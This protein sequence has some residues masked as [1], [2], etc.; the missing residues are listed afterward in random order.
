MYNYSID[1]W[2]LSPNESPI[3]SIGFCVAESSTNSCRIISGSTSILLDSGPAEAK[4][5]A[6]KAIEN[7]LL[8]TSNVQSY[9]PNVVSAQFLR[10]R[11]DSLVIL[12]ADIGDGDNGTTSSAAIVAIGT[13][14]VALLLV[15]TFVYG[16]FRRQ[17]SAKKQQRTLGICT[18]KSPPSSFPVGMNGR[19]Y[20]TRLDDESGIDS[21][22]VSNIYEIKDEPSITWSMSDITSESGSG[23]SMSSR[24]TTR[25]ESIKEEPN[26]GCDTMERPD[27]D[28]TKAYAAHRARLAELIKATHFESTFGA[29]AY[30]VDDAD[31]ISNLKRAKHSKERN[32]LVVVPLEILQSPSLV[33]DESEPEMSSNEFK[34]KPLS[35]NAGDDSNASASE[36]SDEDSNVKT[37]E[38]SKV[39]INANTSG[40]ADNDSKIKTAEDSDEDSNINKSDASGVDSN[41]KASEGSTG[42]KELSLNEPVPKPFCE[43]ASDFNR[44]PNVSQCYFPPSHSTNEQSR[45]DAFGSSNNP[46]QH[47]TNE[48][49]ETIDTNESD[50]SLQR[51]L[52]ILLLEL[53]KCRISNQNESMS[54]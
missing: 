43:A 32:L 2:R 51:W 41:D 42:G 46:D 15:A 17:A 4:T 33:T 38:P 3:C 26:P 19:R 44:S 9:V 14:S 29:Y 16:I 1:E 47:F 27:G 8:N 20:F 12:N 48:S 45:D 13:S 34:V 28:Y 50:A 30:E 6:Y 54:I 52:M 7:G 39:C 10:A 37:S 35:A 25:L 24:A 23:H 40:A 36:A 5:L 31:R 18:P 21:V 49:M 22:V 11:G 53:Q